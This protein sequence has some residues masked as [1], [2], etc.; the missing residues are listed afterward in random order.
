MR[1]KLLAN[2][3]ERSAWSQPQNLSKD[4]QLLEAKRTHSRRRSRKGI[5]SVS[6]HMD[7]TCS[8]QATLT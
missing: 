4:K 2:P 8:A 5:I 7:T 6:I 3:R 1:L